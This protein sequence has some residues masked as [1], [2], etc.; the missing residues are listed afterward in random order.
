M[1]LDWRRPVVF[2]HRWLGIVCGLL[3]ITWFASGIVMMYARMPAISAAERAAR[4]PRLNL[5]GATVSLG[6]AAARAGGSPQRLRITMW[7]DRPV[8]RLSIGGRTTTIFAD[9]GEPLGE[10]SRQDALDEARRF[11]PEHAATMAYDSR[12]RT[13]DQ[14]TIEH[15]ALMPLHRIALGDTAGTHLYISAQ[16]GEAVQ[17]T[18]RTSRTWGYA[19]AVIHWVYF[20]PF[21]ANG[22]LWTQFIIWSSIVGLLMCLTGLVWGVWQYLSARSRYSGWMWWHHYAGLIFGVT[23]VT[24]LFSGLLSMEPWS[25][26]PGTAPTRQQRE[27]ATGGPLDL[28]EV[29]ADRLRAAAAALGSDDFTELDVVQFQG[30]P[31][32][33]SARQLVSARTP[34]RGAFAA[35][36][37]SAMEATA[38]AAMPGIPIQDKIWLESYDAYYYARYDGPPLPLPVLRVRYGDPVRTWLYLDPGRGAVVRKEE[39][40]TR[41]NRWLYHGLHSWDFPFLYDKRPLWDI[42]VIALSIGGLISSVTTIVPA[43]NRLRRQARRL[44][45]RHPSSPTLKT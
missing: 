41:L 43:F 42:V 34:E 26:H 24:F 6:D 38:V 37:R 23:T 8:Y 13:P 2:T 4:A 25:W 28:E 35:F 32:I 14:W 15:R 22:A 5:S 11:A 27:A 17:K 44:T 29:T 33:R 39:R 7:G 19:G 12:L 10:A 1:R 18:T 9:T 30:E 36:D 3:F 45:M 40:L 20:T 16:T 31:Y 21:R